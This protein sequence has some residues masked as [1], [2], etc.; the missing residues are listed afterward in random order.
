MS[1][2][3]QKAVVSLFAAWGFLIISQAVYEG[4]ISVLHV[5]MALLFGFLVNGGSKWGRRSCILY[6][7]VMIIIKGFQLR[8]LA[9]GQAMG[10]PAVI[11]ALVTIILFLLSTYYLVILE[12]SQPVQTEN[13][14]QDMIIPRDQRDN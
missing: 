1:S 2:P 8:Q 3:A 12:T 14:I 13:N 5:S 9:G 4:M 7:S 6:N 11:I 10:H